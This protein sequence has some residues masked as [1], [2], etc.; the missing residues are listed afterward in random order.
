MN[1]LHE[2]AMHEAG[3]LQTVPF[4]FERS[5]ATRTPYLSISLTSRKYTMCERDGSYLRIVVVL[6]QDKVYSDVN[7]FQALVRV[8][9]NDNIFCVFGT[10]QDF[11][12]QCRTF[13]LLFSIP[14]P[15][16]IGAIELLRDI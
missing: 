10:W 12:C 15:I 3:N 1:C 11:F 2:S 9:R 7:S 4:H 5:T 13:G 16:F 8:K 6:S 14:I